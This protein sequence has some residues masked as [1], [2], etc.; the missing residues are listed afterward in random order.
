VVDA[1]GDVVAVV[2]DATVVVVV[3]PGV[4]GAVVVDATVVVVVEAVGGAVVAVVVETVGAGWL[5]VVPS[6]GC[7]TSTTMQ[8]PFK[9]DSPAGQFSPG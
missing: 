4:V 8:P 6:G 5:V 1:P 7:S 3:A 2:E 9:M